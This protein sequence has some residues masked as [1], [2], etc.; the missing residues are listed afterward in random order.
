MLLL[1]IILWYF[2]NYETRCQGGND[3]LLLHLFIVVVFCLKE[4][5]FQFYILIVFYLKEQLFHF[6]IFTE[7]PG[8]CTYTYLFS[9]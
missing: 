1:K 6:C 2:D 4:Q 8:H 7:I 9:F 5:L 3:F